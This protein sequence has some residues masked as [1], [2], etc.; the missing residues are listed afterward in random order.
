M[1]G[2]IGGLLGIWGGKAWMGW[3]Y[4]GLWRFSWSGLD[5]CRGF[6]GERKRSGRFELSRMLVWEEHSDRGNWSGY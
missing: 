6:F 1:K 5:G 3:K 2:L 4:V